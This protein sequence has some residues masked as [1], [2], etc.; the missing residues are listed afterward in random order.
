MEE[1]TTRIREEIQLYSLHP[2]FVVNLKYYLTRNSISLTIH[3]KII[4]KKKYILLFNVKYDKQY[5]KKNLEKKPL[6]VNKKVL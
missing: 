2:S 4:N 3:I 6:Q 1:Y 5:K